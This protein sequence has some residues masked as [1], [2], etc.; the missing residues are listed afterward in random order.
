MNEEL[1]GE[2][3]DGIVAAQADDE[4]AWE[5]PSQVRRSDARVESENKPR[6]PQGQRLVE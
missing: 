1:S 6:N 2:E 3:V 4:S 5:E